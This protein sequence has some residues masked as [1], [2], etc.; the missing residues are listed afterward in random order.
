MP[1]RSWAEFGWNRSPRSLV[2]AECAR[3]QTKGWVRQDHFVEV[4]ISSINDRGRARARRPPLGSNQ[5][6]MT[7]HFVLPLVAPRCVIQHGDSPSAQLHGLVLLSRSRAVPCLVSTSE[8]LVD[9]IAAQNLTVM[10]ADV[11]TA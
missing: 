11:R 9:L 1:L 6:R 5:C 2:L 10:Q 7:V 4:R 3:S 8:V